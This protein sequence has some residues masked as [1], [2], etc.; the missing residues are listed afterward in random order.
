MKRIAIFLALVL[1]GVTP[2]VAAPKSVAVKKL[3]LVAV[4]Q[5]AEKL[6][7]S[8]KTIVTVGN[9][10]GANSNIQLTGLDINGLQLWQK[11]IDSG[12]DEVAL[13]AAT[14][15]SGNIWLA[16]ASSAI[17]PSESETAQIQ[18]ENPDGVVV[19]P[20]SKFRGDM[21]LLTFWKVSAAGDL[22]ATYTSAQSAPALISA[23]SANSSGVSVAGSL[24]GK[25]FIQSV[26][27]QGVF[28]KLISIGTSKSSLN[29]IVRHADGTLS[30]FGTS[31]ET[32][33]GKKLAGARDGV[34]IKVSKTG[35]I[36]SVVRSSA[37]KADRAWIAADSSLALTG[38]VKTGKVIESAFTKF[39]TAFAPTWTLRVPSLG[40]SAVI[41]AGNT[42]YGAFASNSPV[43]NVVGWKPTA[44]SLLLLSFD[45]KGV[46]TG[47]FGSS[48]LMEPIELAYSKEVGFIGLAKTANQ[49]ISLF[50]LP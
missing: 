1:V 33:G 3:T 15:P 7:I 26:S 44:P 38:Y 29:A 9:S 18:A 12:V 21:N 6:V 13:A 17:L 25:P 22:I 8:G 36:A 50:K 24:Q 46:V 16:G 23:I 40:T 32:L 35:A 11:T 45:S 31:A 28:G 30:A 5:G 43:S 14:D 19:E 47:A 10:D 37:P 20:I 42:T 27:A 34:L 39:T 49:S 41:S 48:E 4:N 2:A